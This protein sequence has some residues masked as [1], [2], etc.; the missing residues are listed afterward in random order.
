MDEYSIAE[1]R[2]ILV[3]ARRAI[4]QVQEGAELAAEDAY[5][6]LRLR[7]A[8]VNARARLTSDEEF[9]TMLPTLAVRREMLALDAWVRVASGNGSRRVVG[10]LLLRSGAGR[11]ASLPFT[12]R[13]VGELWIVGP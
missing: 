8:E 1:L 5:R 3:A 11:K 9:D 6:Q 7:A 13:R 2:E 10:E 12:A 4:D